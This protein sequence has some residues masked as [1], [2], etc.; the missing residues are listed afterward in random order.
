MTTLGVVVSVR[1]GTQ[2]P[3]KER[4]PKFL[5]QASTNSVTS[6]VRHPAT[7]LFAIFSPFFSSLFLCWSRCIKGYVNGS[8]FFLLLLT[9]T[10]PPSQNTTT[11]PPTKNAFLTKGS[12]FFLSFSPHD[13]DM[14][15]P[16]RPTLAR[17]GFE[18]Q[19]WAS[20]SH[21]VCTAEEN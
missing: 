5:S 18:E 13:S 19:K 7:C 20:H 4:G 10:A 11:T 3:R 21:C 14:P 2:S 15:S 16:G 9:T 8:H 6:S 12:P 17:V 1:E